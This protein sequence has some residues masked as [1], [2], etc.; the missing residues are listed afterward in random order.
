MPQGC[1][2]IHGQLL[3]LGIELSKSTIC[4]ILNESF[5]DGW[6]YGQSWWSF[7]RSQG[8]RIWACD[9]FTVETASLRKVLVFFIIDID[10]RE[11]MHYDIKLKPD[12]TWLKNTL[13][14]FF[15][16]SQILPD[17]LVSDNDP[18]FKR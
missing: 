16:F 15:S 9:Y 1:R 13:R 14:S 18:T 4:N 17:V 2:R 6:H 11:I 7:I 10:T 3:K 5:P 12:S 8:K